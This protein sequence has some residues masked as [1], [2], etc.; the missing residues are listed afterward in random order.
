SATRADVPVRARG[1]YL[2]RSRRGP[3][4]DGRAP[5]PARLRAAARGGSQRAPAHPPTGGS[6]ALQRAAGGRDRERLGAAA[7]CFAAVR[8]RWFYAA[9]MVT[10][11]RQPPRA[12]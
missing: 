2:R 5:D 10:D 12:F 1:A 4:P 11:A 8:G 9:A 6:R 7:G 3:P